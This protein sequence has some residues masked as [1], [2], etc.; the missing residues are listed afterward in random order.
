MSTVASTVRARVSFLLD[1]L[2][3]RVDRD[4]DEGAAVVEFVMMTLLLVLLLFAVL[5][6]AVFM[7][8]RNIV[9]ASAA[10]G[11]RYGANAG[12][13]PDAGADKANSLVATGLTHAAARRISC[14]AT[15]TRDAESGVRVVQ[16]R[17]AGS[18]PMVLLPFAMPA[19]ITVA[20]AALKEGAP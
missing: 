20:S 16:V 8:A 5:Q 6:L 4:G 2:R 7:Y 10:A 18:V 13:E 14:T 19:H 3:R 11:A 12:I 17:C 9:A 15:E 1:R